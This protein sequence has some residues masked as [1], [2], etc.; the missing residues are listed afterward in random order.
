MIRRILQR[1][2]KKEADRIKLLVGLGN[3]GKQHAENRHNVGFQVLDRLAARY[4]LSFDKI[5]FQGLLARGKVAGETVLLL[6]PLTYMNRCGE[7][8]K[9]V[10]ARY[11][12]STEDLL[13]IY[14]DLDLPVGKIRIRERSSSGGHKGLESVIASLGT[15]NIARVRIGIGRPNGESPEEYVLRDFSLDE[16][17]IIEEARERAIAAAVCFVREGIAATMNTYN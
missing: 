13:V 4:Q 12:I 14:D 8:V 2:P 15:Q 1:R 11:D 10:Q 5:E 9:P 3:P 6:K 17:I 7:A 16:S